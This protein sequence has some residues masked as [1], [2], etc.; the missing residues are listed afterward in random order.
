MFCPTLVKGVIAYHVI[1]ILG[2]VSKGMDKKGGTAVGR[3][4]PTFK[5]GGGLP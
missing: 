5:W 3:S 2:Y 4:G 1:G